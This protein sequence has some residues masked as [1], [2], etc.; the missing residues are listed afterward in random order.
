MRVVV[1]S[2]ASRHNALPSFS[3]D[4]VRAMRRRGIEAIE[5]D[6]T[7]PTDTQWVSDK[8]KA[9]A[10]IDFSFSFQ[11]LTRF[12]DPDGKTVTEITRAPLVSQYVDHPLLA[13]HHLHAVDPACALLTVDPSHVDAINAIFGADHF[14][15]AGFSPHG[16]IGETAALPEDA[17]HFT[18]A[19]PIPILFAGCYYQL[20]PAYP[21][22]FPD[23]IKSV[24]RDA[25]DIAMAEEWLAPLDALDRALTARGLALDDPAL[26]QD[27]LTIRGMSC[28]VGEYVRAHRRALFFEA[29]RKIGLKLTVYGVGFEAIAKDHP[30]IAYRGTAD[31]SEILTLMRQSRMVVNTNANF[32]RGSHER[33]F[34]AMLAGAAAASDTSAYYRRRFDPGREIALFRW[35]YLQEDLAAIRDLAADPH[36]LLAMARAGQA[37]AQA[38]ERWDNRIDSILEAARVARARL[39]LSQAA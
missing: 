6:L 15:H 39:N 17:A 5:C 8:L 32:G 29:A 2:G 37:K 4:V 24:F 11:I 30:N 26:R 18:A 13:G 38:N 7:G 28:H 3:R 33:P 21:D 12:R 27:L 34:S 9:L 1:F 10:P 23:N 36:A 16:G 19:R 31:F 22:A 20:P 14:A 25:C 35:Q